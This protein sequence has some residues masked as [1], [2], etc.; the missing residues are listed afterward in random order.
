M[1]KKG[2]LVVSFRCAQTIA[3]LDLSRSFKGV[4]VLGLLGF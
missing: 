2:E 3:S 1:E 4:Y